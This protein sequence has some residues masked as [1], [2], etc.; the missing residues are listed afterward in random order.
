MA[1]RN[2]RSGFWVVFL[3]L[4]VALGGCAKYQARSAFEE[5]EELKSAEQY[6]QA[7]EKYFEAT[8]EDPGN[9]TYKLKLI[10]G[11][12]R[13]AAF[14]IDKA[15]KLVK[16]DKLEEA[17]AQYRLARGFDPSVEVAALEARQLQ[18]V[19]SARQKLEEGFVR[20]REKRYGAARQ[21]VNEVLKVDP[22]NPRATEL[23]K[24]LDAKYQA[25]VMDGVELDVASTE[26]I[27][28]RFK[29]ANIK[30]VFGI[31]TQLSGINFLLDD[32]VKDKSIT[33]LLE[34]AT[35]SQ[36]MELILSMAGL[37]KKVLNSK[38]MI[39]YTQGKEK[40]K[41]YEDQIIQSFYLSHIDA[42]KAVNLLRTMLQLRKVYV[43]EE[44]N[45][46]VIRDT[47]ETIKLAEQVLKAADREN[48]EVLFDLELVS[49]SDT[50]KLKF[51]PELSAYSTS[52][53]F[54]KSAI[55]GST[56]ISEKLA[57]GDKIDNL[58]QSVNNLQTFYTLPTATFN[59]AK[60]LSGT[61]ILASPKIRV[62][63]SEKAKVHI[64]TR[65]PIVTVTTTGE[66]F[67]D[68]IQY[69][70][71]GVKVDV[72]PTIQL[73]DAVQTKL[74]LEVSQI[75]ERLP[76]TKNGSI[77]LRISTTNAQTVLTLKDGVQT[78][79]GGLFSQDQSKT[80]K[81]IPFLGNIPIIG[82]I[83]S[84]LENSDTKSE[85]LLSITP[86]IVKQIEVP[87]SDVAT[88]WSGGEDDLMA[89]PKFGAF[90]Q[91][92][93]SE[94]EAIIPAAAPSQSRPTRSAPFPAL[95]GKVS[96]VPDGAGTAQAEAASQGAAT[97][98]APAIAPVAP[99]ASPVSSPAPAGPMADSLLSQPPPVVAPGAPV[100]AAPFVPAP[101]PT[102][103]PAPGASSAPAAV[104]PA[105]P[106]AT[107]ASAPPIVLPLPPKGPAR[108]GISGAEASAVGQEL[109]L[110][111]QVS[112]VERLYSAPLFVNYDPALLEFVEANE[113]TFLGQGG[114]TTV[115]S[116][117][118]NVAAGQVVV[119]YKQGV[120]GGG[121][122]GDGSLF[123]LRFRAKAPGSARVEL[124]RVNFRDPAGTRLAVESSTASVVIR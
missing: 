104:V 24:L 18:E 59:L 88:I 92:L 36:A 80:K 85:I 73:N 124:N 106:A 35:F 54:S 7:V 82:D 48:S 56:I 37:D 95:Q 6:D 70:D 65:E 31:L 115:F 22:Q 44:R 38:T 30:E 16:E 94:V 49:V 40:E 2:R 71:V 46:L 117:S 84:S 120:G 105:A 3:L 50:D 90:A 81:T 45:A 23:L 66:T 57:S 116:Y 33:V 111:I 75:V 13:A 119:G 10:A 77:P 113:G 62:R 14:H 41:Q 109:T 12:T 121:A 67:S 39:I 87:G 98:V 15:R 96:A 72:E 114:Q 97:P 29:Q 21:I 102:A 8:Q 101:V 76:A 58:I 43:H 53:G 69:I 47:P 25:V 68:N 19:V 74:T 93:L 63:N 17:L 123:T 112:G 86:Y 118:P 83:I 52:V 9:K 103:T 26:P 91:P 100:P 79:I 27:T 78:I 1:I 32:E 5:A 122:S 20:Y 89:R 60:T 34:K 64:G 4:V 99:P 55:A 107:P 108:L 42:K 110:A 11:R 51:G 28:L 61:E